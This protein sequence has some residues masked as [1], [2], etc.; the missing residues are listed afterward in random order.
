LIASVSFPISSW[1]Q[2]RG[3]VRQLD[4]PRLTQPFFSRVHRSPRRRFRSATAEPRRASEKVWSL[5]SELELQVAQY[6]DQTRSLPPFFRAFDQ[7]PY[8]LPNAARKPPL[9]MDSR[10]SRSAAR[11][12]DNSESVEISPSIT[13]EEMDGN[14]YDGSMADIPYADDSDFAQ[15]PRPIM[16]MTSQ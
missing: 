16:E 10:E 14:R 5:Y 13:I 4:Y 9:P 6:F 11:S 12:E 8:R 15:S 2:H 3:S 1:R 7:T